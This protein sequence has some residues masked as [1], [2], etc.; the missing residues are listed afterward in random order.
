MFGIALAILSLGLL[1]RHRHFWQTIDLD[2]LESQ[3]Q[4]YFRRQY[5]RRVSTSAMIGIVGLAII[6]AHWVISPVLVYVYLAGLMLAVCSILLMALL[7]FWS[8]RSFLYDMRRRH[9]RQRAE[10]E[11][12]VHRLRKARETHEGNG[13]EKSSSDAP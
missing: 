6:A 10:L 7:D 9:S 1:W 2:K 11:A 4:T 3:E 5:R 12:E 13:H 8:T